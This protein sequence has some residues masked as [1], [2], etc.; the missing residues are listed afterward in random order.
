M[1]RRFRRLAQIFERLI[2]VICE[3]CGLFFGIA[4]LAASPQNSPRI[5][6]LSPCISV[7]SSSYSHSIVP[8]GLEVMS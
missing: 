5:S 8:G 4:L 3:I 6:A 7:S 2:C 1:I